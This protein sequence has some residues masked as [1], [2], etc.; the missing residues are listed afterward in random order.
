MVAQGTPEEVAERPYRSA[1][2]KPGDGHS[3]EGLGSQLD[4]RQ[5]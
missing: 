4:R 2:A 1:L 5:P 3:A